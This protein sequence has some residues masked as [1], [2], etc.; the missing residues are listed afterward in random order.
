MGFRLTE[1]QE[2]LRES[3]ERF[4]R[5]QYGVEAWRAPPPPAPRVGA[6]P[7]GEMGGRGGGAPARGGGYGG[8]GLGPRERSVIM[9]SL[10]RG[11]ALEPFWSTAVLGAE[12]VIATATPA[13]K[14]DF[15]PRIADGSLRLAFALAES[16]SRYQWTDV[17]CRAER[18]GDGYRIPGHKIA[19]LDAASAHRLLVLARTAGE[20]AAPEGLSLFWVDGRAKGVERRDFLT[21]D[22]RRCS[23]IRF[24][25]VEVSRSQLLGAEGQAAGAVEQAMDHAMA[26]LCAEAVGAMSAVLQTTVEYLKTRKQF[27]KNLSEFQA[28]RHRVADMVI[29][30][31]QSR[32]ISAMSAMCLNGDVM[33]RKRI[34]A[35]AKVQIGNAGRFVGE[36]AVQ[37]HGGIGIS[38]DLHVG[39]YLKR[40]MVINLLLGD[41]SFHLKRFADLDGS[42]ARS[43]DTSLIERERKL[44][45][46]AG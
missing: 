45:E 38:D 14:Q 12:L 23:D 9:E 46:L 35:A 21:L 2:Q 10:G 30:T 5:E 1:D 16:G 42:A 33:Q 4:V 13:Q 7:G 39:H 15:L 31:E 44:V 19:V 25:A 22:E 37:L 34:V 41:A 11:L 36:S 3:V 24:D 6:D 40:L 28:L 26:A 18:H 27:G 29:A 20:D 17:R 43:I 8:V 32:S